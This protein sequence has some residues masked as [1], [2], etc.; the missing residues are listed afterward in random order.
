[1]QLQG[2]TPHL[3]DRLDRDPCMQGLV[4]CLPLPSH[5]Y[6]QTVMQRIAPKDVDRC[7]PCKLR[8]LASRSARRRPRTSRAVM[9]HPEP[10]RGAP[11]HGGGGDRRVAL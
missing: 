10:P 8:C 11:G 9:T 7:H 3:V 5:L 2:K 4:V 6:G 1:M